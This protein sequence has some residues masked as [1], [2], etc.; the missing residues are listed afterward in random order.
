MWIALFD[1]SLFLLLVAFFFYGLSAWDRLLSEP[2]PSGD[3]D[4]DN[5]D[6]ETG[7][8]GGTRGDTDLPPGRFW[9]IWVLV[10]GCGFVSLT[11]DLLTWLGG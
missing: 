6:D 2:A 7:S 1:F 8:S 3:G 11:A 9:A 4:D 5:D 10:F